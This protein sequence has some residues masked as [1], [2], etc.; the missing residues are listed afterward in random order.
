MNLQ[1]IC[2][3]GLL[4]FP[5]QLEPSL[6]L[7]PEAERGEATKLLGKLKGLPKSELIQ[8]WAKLREEELAVLQRTAAERAGLQLDEL[9]P[10]IRPWCVSW[11]ADH[12][13]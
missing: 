2:Y 5:E 12:N 4:R 13:G 10:S 7:L 9:P 3:L 8:R 6:A 11:I 1:T